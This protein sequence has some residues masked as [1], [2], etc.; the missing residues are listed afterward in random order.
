M[1]GNGNGV[2]AALVKKTE[3]VYRIL[4][5]NIVGLGLLFPRILD[6]TVAELRGRDVEL[7]PAINEHYREQLVS[8]KREGA[9]ADNCYLEVLSI[10]ESAN[11]RV[12]DIR[13]LAEQYS[14]EKTAGTAS[15]G[16]D[17]PFPLRYP[18][19]GD[20]QKRVPDLTIEH[21]I[22]GINV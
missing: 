17:D 6:V 2:S 9:F 16:L 11:A 21:R 10:I 18:V 19:T 13:K 5:S 1:S 3:G 20:D 14:R 4:D 12:R 22:P 8:P 7:Q 15:V